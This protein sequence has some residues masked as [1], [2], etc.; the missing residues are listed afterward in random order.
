MNKYSELKRDYDKVLGSLQRSLP[1]E[2]LRDDFFRFYRSC[3]LKIWSANE[4]YSP[5]YA[6]LLTLLSGKDYSID[7][8]IT[9]MSLFSESKEQIVLPAFYEKLLEA[10][11]QSEHPLVRDFLP[12]FNEL[13]VASAI[14]NGDFTREEADALTDGSEK[15]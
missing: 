8:V 13:M 11:R 7:L 3:I 15:G 14:I 6:N 4:G 12:D 2:G 10:G 1:K 5:D 9:G